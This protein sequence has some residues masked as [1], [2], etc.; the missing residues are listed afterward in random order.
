MIANALSFHPRMS[1]CPFSRTFDL[2]RF[3]SSTFSPIDSE[4]M[5]IISANTSMPPIVTRKATKRTPVPSASACV[6]GSA[7]NVHAC[8]MV[9]L[10]ES[11]DARQSE[12]APTR[13]SANVDISSSTDLAHLDV[14]KKWSSRYCAISTTEKGTLVSAC[15][16][17]NSKY[18]R[19]MIRPMDP[20][21]PRTRQ[22]AIH[23]KPSACG[24]F[25]I[26]L[27]ASVSAFSR[28]EQEV[29]PPASRREFSR[30]SLSYSS[31]AAWRRSRRVT[32]EAW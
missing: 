24:A 8:H 3:S 26:S 31:S 22:P 13:I 25:G 9:M 20:I 27:V 11:P 15:F 30:R 10:S 21:P 32:W 6:P 17:W 16:L 28:T 23:G 18:S 14:E 5:P 7:T 12:I 4:I 19:P 29:S 2:P 1:E